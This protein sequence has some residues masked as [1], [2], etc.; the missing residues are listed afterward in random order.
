MTTLT[1]RR[2][3]V[4]F[5]VVAP[6][7]VV[8]WLAAWFANLPLANLAAYDLLWLEQGSHLGDAIAFFFLDV[9]KV[10]LLL[11]GIMTVVS[12]L[13]SYFPPERMRAALAGRGTVP[14]TVGAAAFGVVTPFCSCSAVPLFIGFVEAGIPLGVTFAFRSGSPMVNEV[15]LVLLWGLFGPGIAI[16]Y[17]AAGLTVAV[18]GGLVLGRLPLEKWIEPWVLAVRAGGGATSLD[19]RLSVEQRM[20][21]AW[22]STKDLVRRVLLYV[23]IGIGIGAVIHGFVSTEFVSQSGGRDN[24]FA[25][26]N[27]VAIA[28]PLYSNALGTIPIVEALLGKGMPLGTTL[29]F[30]MA[31]VAISLPEFVILRRVMQLRLIAVFGG[32]V[33]AGILA[34]GFLFNALGI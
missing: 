9:P 5:R 18:V 3:H 8:A 25:V 27:V 4:P 1:V 19:L 17:M 15:A 16:L 32:V 10:L 31:I 26:P 21:D 6:V 13:R 29:A 12:F 2:V 28:I 7:V 22:T 24:P 23:I 34:V 11:L 20:R 30:M 14:A 33:V